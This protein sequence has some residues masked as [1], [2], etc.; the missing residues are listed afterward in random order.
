MFF[1]CEPIDELAG[2]N[3]FALD[4]RAAAVWVHANALEP[5]PLVVLMNDARPLAGAGLLLPRHPPAIARN[6]RLALGIMGLMGLM[7]SGADRDDLVDSSRAAEKQKRRFGLGR[8]YKQVT[9]LGFHFTARSN[10]R[11]CNRFQGCGEIWERRTK[12]RPN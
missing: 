1:I 11:W 8:S 4:Q 6:G 5:E 9:P 3:Q 10:V 2:G 12:Q 7:A